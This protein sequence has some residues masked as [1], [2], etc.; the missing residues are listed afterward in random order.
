LN[1]EQVN[2]LIANLLGMAQ[3]SAAFQA[4]GGDFG[5]LAKDLKPEKIIS[6]V[7]ALAGINPVLGAL[8]ISALGVNTAGVQAADGLAELFGGLE[9]FGQ[10]TS[11]YYQEFFSDTEREAYRLE[12]ANSQLNS[13]F[14]EL[15]MEVPKTREEFR[16]LVSSL[17]LSTESG[18]RLFK[19]LMDLAG[20]ADV[21]YDAAEAAA[22]RADDTTENA[23]EQTTATNSLTAAQEA[24]MNEVHQIPPAMSEAGNAISDFANRAMQAAQSLWDWLNR[25]A[26]GDTSS[27]N[28]ME[29][30]AEAERQAM[31]LYNAAM[32]G[33][34]EAAGKLPQA[35]DTVLAQRR[36]VYGSQG[37]ADYEAAI[38]SGAASVAGR[39]GGTQPQASAPVSG[40][41]PAQAPQ[42]PAPQQPQGGGGFGVTETLM[43]TLVA[44]LVD[45]IKTGD[46]EQE[47]LLKSVIQRFDAAS[48]YVARNIRMTAGAG[49][50][51]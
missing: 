4:M 17:D 13:G 15:G 8:R 30:L 7:Q 29:K 22:E 32:A 42:L 2:S 10:A 16:A 35:L 19:A 25:Q 41:A 5:Q 39:M 23:E 49:A 24:Y 44:Q 51:W 34:V 33:D 12:S 20:A 36:A 9:Q 47:K 14:E 26:L 3:A 1:E 45:A 28:P 38:R 46:A 18:R 43:R 31:N 40:Q 11:A 37:Y 21:T 6:G 48:E 27:L 50:S